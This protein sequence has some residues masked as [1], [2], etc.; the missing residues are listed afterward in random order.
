M[1]Q[2]SRQARFIKAEW[3]K[4]GAVVVDAGYHR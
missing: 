3:I 1:W 2:L 4:D